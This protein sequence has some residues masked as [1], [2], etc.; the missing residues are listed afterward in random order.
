MVSNQLSPVSHVQPQ[1]D[2]HF[3]RSVFLPLWYWRNMNP[4]SQAA[5][6]LEYRETPL[7]TPLSIPSRLFVVRESLG[8][9]WTSMFSLQYNAKG[10]WIGCLLWYHCDIAKEF[11]ISK[12][13]FSLTLPKLHPSIPTPPYQSAGIHN[14]ALW[15]NR[16]WLLSNYNLF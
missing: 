10:M 4:E 3:S 9:F 6:D 13:F 16:F 14:L 7:P 2:S 8:P 11:L 12:Q 1:H 5:E 15:I